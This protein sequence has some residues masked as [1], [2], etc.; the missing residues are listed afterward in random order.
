MS[1]KKILLIVVGIAL[2]ITAGLFFYSNDSSETINN[3]NESTKQAV[4]IEDTFC[5]NDRDCPDNYTCY[6]PI[7]CEPTEENCIDQM[8]DNTCHRNCFSN[9][10]CVSNTECLRVDIFVSR[11]RVPAR[12]CN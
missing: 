11:V 10:D 12:I 3:Q 8:G 6:I 1:Q 2:I 4:V 5:Q 9:S 7:Q